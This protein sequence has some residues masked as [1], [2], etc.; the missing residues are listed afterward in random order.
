MKLRDVISPEACLAVDAA[1]MWLDAQRKRPFQPIPKY[2]T[3]RPGY[4]FTARECAMLR[5][6]VKDAVWQERG[7]MSTG[8]RG[9]FNPEGYKSAEEM[10]ESGNGRT[11]WLGMPDWAKNWSLTN[12]E[13]SKSVEDAI[14]GEKLTHK[15]RLLLQVML[16]Q[17]AEA[18]AGEREEPCPF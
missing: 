10:N 15:R 18:D 3:F 12:D 16:E 4:R 9:Q 17:V 1:H 14:K 5:Q 11:A 2:R 13:M 8:W 7:G 6:M